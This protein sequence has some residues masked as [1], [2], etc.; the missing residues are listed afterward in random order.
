MLDPMRSGD[1]DAAADWLQTFLPG[2]CFL[3]R[4]RLGKP[5]VEPEA[6]SVLEAALQAGQ[7]DGSVTAEQLPGLIRRLITQRFP[8]KSREYTLA[9]SAAIKAAARTLSKMS[10]LERDALRRCYVVGEAPE[11][12]VSGLKL[13]LEE[14]RKIQSRARAE[15]SA[16]K[17][18]Q[19]NVA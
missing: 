10:P 3:I 18:K 13:T 14:L 4:R 1:P 5:D 16:A 7:T 15:F 11:S 17:P 8:E 9:S 12:I 2:T 19:A 6:R